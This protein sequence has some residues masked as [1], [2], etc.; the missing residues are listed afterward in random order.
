MRVHGEH[1]FGENSR[2]VLTLLKMPYLPYNNQFKRQ[3]RIFQQALGSRAVPAYHSHIITQTNSFLHDIVNDPLRYV[4]HARKYAGGLTLLVVYGYKVKNNQ[5]EFL[6]L[7]EE[8]LGILANE[9]NTGGG[10]WLV[11]I[12]PILKSYPSWLP[13]GSFKS[14]AAA[15]KVTMDKFAQDPL[16]YAKKEI[17]RA[18][19]FVLSSSMVRLLIGTRNC[20][21]IVL[22]QAIQERGSSQQGR[23]SRSKMDKLFHVRCE[24]R[25]RKLPI[26]D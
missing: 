23:D 8:C 7:A 15:W 25:H 3:R 21:P 24:C 19:F 26:F 4:R 12:F 5:D 6:L 11:D 10:V 14:R 16:D 1:L 18:L 20:A 13:G 22:L 17:V 9:V 2:R